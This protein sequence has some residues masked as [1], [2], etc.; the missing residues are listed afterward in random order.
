MGR[1]AASPTESP[2]GRS[3]DFRR[4]RKRA[5]CTSDRSSAAS[6]GAATADCTSAR[7]GCVRG[8]HQLV[9]GRTTLPKRP[10]SGGPRGF[11]R[12]ALA[13]V[14]AGESQAIAKTARSHF[15]R[16]KVPPGL[17]SAI[18]AGMHPGPDQTPTATRPVDLARTAP[19]TNW[20]LAPTGAR[21]TPDCPSLRPVATAE[22]L[23]RTRALRGHRVL[24]DRP[25]PVSTVPICWPTERRTGENT[26]NSS[27]STNVKAWAWT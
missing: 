15:S 5:T 24:A 8:P 3:S 10:E 23:P 14:L 4:A 22:P 6:H 18:R 16:R 20:R 27:R 17:R 25:R 26:P 11:A 9:D 21:S 19:D 12:S 13:P 7:G 1:E 2:P